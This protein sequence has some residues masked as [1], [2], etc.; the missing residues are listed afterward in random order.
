M[1]ITVTL[2]P[3]LD[4]T[5]RVDTMRPNALNRL[6]NVMLDAGGK[7]VNV[8]AM[9]QALGGVSI[10]AGFA[11]GST[12]DE[13]LARIEQKGLNHDF[14]RIAAITRTNLKVIADNG[15]LTELNEPGPDISRTELAA[16]EE[17]LLELAAEG[18]TFVL[19]GSLPKGTE[20]DMYK[21]LCGILR[22]KNAAVFLDADGLAL[23]L[24][25]DTAP[26]KAPDF[27][28]PNRCELLNL[29]GIEDRNEISE[30]ALS[31]LCIKLLDRGVT[32]VALSMGESGA[33]FVC[34]KGIWR[35]PA[36]PVI[37]R[38]TVGAGDS[39]VGA[40]VY[41]FEKGLALEES[42]ALAMAASAGACTTEGTNPPSRALVDD[43][44]SRVILHKIA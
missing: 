16:I 38:S 3:A 24:A 1:I 25:L 12:G 35:S 21:K 37:V 41:G 29:F 43:L 10:A 15:A 19:S 14:T 44:L 7:G 5:V 4:K 22:E 31:G 17:K 40:L 30:E 33:L 34:R 39:M 20:S 11:G 27:I 32:L 23:K 13:L 2:N 42:F 18:N 6:R 26:E 8:S 9:I 36:V 28:K